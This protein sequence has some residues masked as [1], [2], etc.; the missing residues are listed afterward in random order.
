MEPRWF[1]VSF[2]FTTKLIFFFF[3]FFAPRT[4]CGWSSEFLFP[5]AFSSS[6]SFPPSTR[7]IP[8][9]A[10]IFLLS[11]LRLLLL[12]ASC[13]YSLRNAY[14]YICICVCVCLCIFLLFA[15]FCSPSSNQNQ[16]AND[17]ISL[18]LCCMCMPTF[19]RWYLIVF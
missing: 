3:F 17:Y 6:C 2:S 18:H 16:Q 9:S 13:C 12:L 15:P 8:T 4:P 5:A 19:W 7:T 1:D 14:I 10:P 11:A